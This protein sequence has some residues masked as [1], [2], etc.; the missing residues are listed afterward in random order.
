M[1]YFIDFIVEFGFVQIVNF[2]TREH[3]ILDVFFT[4]HLTYEYTCKPLAGISA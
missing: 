1:Q 3:N 2:P 4:N